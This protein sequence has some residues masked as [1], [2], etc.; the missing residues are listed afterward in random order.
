MEKLRIGA[1]IRLLRKKNDVTQEQLAGQIGVTP[2][3]VSRWESGIC[4]PDMNYLPPIADFFSVSMDELL[5]YTDNRKERRVQNCI[6][7]VEALLEQ[8]R[9]PDALELLREVMAEVPSSYALRL[10]MAEVLSLYAE[11]VAQRTNG[12]A[13]ARA[14]IGAALGEAVSLCRRILEDCSDDALRDR[15]KKTLCDIYAHQLNDGVQAL[16]I[17]EQFH[18]MAFCREIIKATVLTGE[19]AFRQAQENLILFADNIW[20]HLYNL[21]CV[22]DISGGRYTVDERLTL[23]QTGVDVFRL[24]FGDTPL[25]Y[26]DRLANSCRQMALLYLEKGEPEAALEQ[27]EHLTDYAIAYDRRPTE[28]VYSSTL[29]D[30]VTYSR[31]AD[32]TER[33]TNPE[34]GKCARML[35]QLSHGR[36]FAALRREPRFRAALARLTACARERGDIEA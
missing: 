30:H 15:T 12:G 33:H 29:L 17:A 5:C 10:E 28:A 34:A 23:L 21:A 35:S 19:V 3:A 16:E 4:Y 8:E 18:D 32:A 9:I 20:W 2:Q 1:Q 24:I 6:E 36:A 31:A 26:A 14:A 13:A 11:T 7:Q 22:P 27:I 25:F